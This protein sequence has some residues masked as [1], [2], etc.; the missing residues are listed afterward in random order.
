M[1]EQKQIFTRDEVITILENLRYEVN[2]INAMCCYDELD[3]AIF[4]ERELKQNKKRD[5]L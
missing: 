3:L 4:I 2:E 5:L 1:E